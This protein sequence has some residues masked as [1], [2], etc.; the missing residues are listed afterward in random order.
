MV[1]FAIGTS[2]VLPALSSFCAYA[3]CGILL[4]YVL[5]STF[6]AASV[7]LDARRQR[8][9]RRE[10]CCCCSSARHR[11]AAEAAE[12]AVN[13]SAASATPEPIKDSAGPMRRYFEKL[14]APF[15]LKAPVQI[16]VIV[17]FIGMLVVGIVGATKLKMD[18]R[19]EWFYPDDSYLQVL[20]LLRFLF[21]LDHGKNRVS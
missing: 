15:L 8:A 16:S 2:T 12:A 14:H 4:L 17:V 1:A 19:Y 9:F 7:G 5:M 21:A 3:A 11:E 6:F 20:H 13:P 10:C 18:F